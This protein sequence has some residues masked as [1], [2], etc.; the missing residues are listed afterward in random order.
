MHV[1][2]GAYT[3]LIKILDAV[4]RV[5]WFRARA[6]M[7]RW[8]EEVEILEEEL[9]RM[10]RGCQRMDVVWTKMAE[11]C[12]KAGYKAYA[13]QKAF[14]FKRMSDDANTK[15][16]KAGGKWPPPGV[17]VAQHALSLRVPLSF[18]WSTKS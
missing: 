17:T 3:L 12:E 4:D 11:K 7:E 14:M 18:E 1:I 10:V 16:L 9:W 5:Q 6:D 15:L 2:M 8:Q 13:L